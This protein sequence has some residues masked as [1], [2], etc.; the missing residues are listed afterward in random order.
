MYIP[1][2]EIREPFYAWYDGN[3]GSSRIDYYGGI[4]ENNNILL[5]IFYLNI[6]YV[7]YI[8]YIMNNVHIPYVFYSIGMVKTFQLMNKGEHGASIKVVPV[9]TENVT[10]EETCLQVNG[11]IYMKIQ[12]Q[13]IVPDPSEMEVKK[14]SCKYNKQF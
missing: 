8:A 9:T 2:A 6:D 7:I 5:F 13:T 10:N 12:P 14:N 11:T 3:S 1:Y 4:F